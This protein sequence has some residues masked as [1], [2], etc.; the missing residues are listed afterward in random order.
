MQAELARAEG[1][2]EAALSHYEAY[3]D[4]ARPPERIYIVE[5]VRALVSAISDA[6]AQAVY[7]RAKKTSV[8]AALLATRVAAFARSLGDETQAA[9][10]LAET[11]AIRSALGLTEAPLHEAFVG[12]VLPLAGKRRLVGEAALHGLAL[13]AGVSAASFLAL[14][15]A[16]T[17]GCRCALAC[18]ML[19]LSAV[20]ISTT[21]RS[22]SAMVMIARP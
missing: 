15:V 11:D 13:A 21:G 10:T 12:A 8:V 9:R 1:K 14:P 17:M 16:L 6:Q 4:R 5:Q 22:S 2:A 18:S 19:C 20:M 3:F 7:A